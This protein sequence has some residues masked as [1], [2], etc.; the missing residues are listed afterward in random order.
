M[1]IKEKTGQ[2]R[3]DFTAVYECESCGHEQKDYGYDDSYFH[4]NV[5]PNMQCSECGKSSRMVSSS[6]SIAAEVI[7]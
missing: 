5:I 7:L 2:H 3:R 4:E 6:P 1:R